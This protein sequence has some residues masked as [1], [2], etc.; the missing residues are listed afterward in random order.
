[1]VA[2][3]NEKLKK[4]KT[5][6]NLFRTL[7]LIRSTTRGQVLW[8]L[9]LIVV[10]TCVFFSSF[11]V[12]KLVLNTIAK[13]DYPGKLES[14]I[15]LLAING[16]LTIVYLVLRTLTLYIVEKQSAKVSEYIDEKIHLTATDLDLGFYESPSYFDTMKRAKDAGPDKPNAILSNLI[17][18]TKNGMML[19]AIGS[20]LISINWIL[21]PLLAAFILPTFLVRIRFA[22]RFYKWRRYQTPLERKSAY[23][24]S[25]ITEDVTAKEIRSY[26]LGNY[27]SSL[28]M[29]IRK[30]LV[31]QRLQMVKNNAVNETITT[32]LAVL[33]MFVCVA[34]ICIN[35][36]K[37]RTTIGDI[38]LFLIMFPQ[39][40]NV[41]QS[42]STGISTL[43]HNSIFMNNVFELFDL[44][45][46]FPEPAQPS[47][48]PDHDVDLDVKDLDFTYP[49]ANEKVLNGISLKIPAGKIIAIV[50]LNGAGKTTLIKL[51]SRLYDPSTGE[52]QF[53]G[54]DIRQFKSTD[55]R[56]QISV[57]FQDFGKFN[58]SAA[59]NIRFGNIDETASEEKVKIA[60]MK[61]G[62][63]EFIKKFPAGY[64][65]IM[66]RIFEDGHEVSVGQWQK[67]AIARAFYSD[68]RFLIFDEATSALDAK[69]EKEL[70]ESLR[71][72]IGRRGILIISH[73]LSAVKHADHIYVMSE[74]KIKQ[75]GTHEE[76]ISVPGE[77][78]KLFTKK[79]V[80]I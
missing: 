29:N 15:W 16:L 70:F 72:H 59:D 40:F 46:D 74:G 4:F 67:L 2:A 60:A 9:L 47:L 44:R 27:L 13:N 31:S 48:I 1:M 10:E 23:L 14:V 32:L 7:R 63:H 69:S 65:T 18:L 73:R 52:I 54:I 68:S 17:D 26:G 30:L 21:L 80:V 43:Y 45:S 11:Y 36:V 38:S 57:V 71:E 41:M 50:G 75:Q 62:A 35:A 22:D 20:L 78:S 12:F 79:T 42:L 34:Y 49:H 5:N 25:L 77:Y 3:F 56:K 58:M 55:Y 8:M 37:G 33:G 28:Y 66:G 51:L 39:L 19:L 64:E 6:L 76:L 24:S 53:G 61:S